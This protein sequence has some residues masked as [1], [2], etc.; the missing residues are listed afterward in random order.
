M[1]IMLKNYWQVDFVCFFVVVDKIDQVIECYFV[2]GGYDY[3]VKFVIVGIGEYQMIME[4]LIDMDIG[5][6]KYFSFV[7]LKLLIVK[8]YLLL[9]S[10]FLV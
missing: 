4:C 10:L 6:D 3:F 9:M 7:V 1:E 5:I 8:L 2:F